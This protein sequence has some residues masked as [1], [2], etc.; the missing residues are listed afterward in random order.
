MFLI[1]ISAYFGSE[2]LIRNRTLGRRKGANLEKQDLV[3]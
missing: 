1:A 3:F 2:L